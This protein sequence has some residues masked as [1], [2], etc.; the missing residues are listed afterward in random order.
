MDHILFACG[1]GGT[2]AG[3]ALG[4]RLYKHQQEQQQQQQQQQ[5]EEGPGEEGSRHVL[6]VP[7]IH[8]VGVCDSPDVFYDHIRDM[9]TAVGAPLDVLGDVTEWI[10]LYDGMGLGY[11]QSTTDELAYL[12]AVSQATGTST[13]LPSLPP[14]SLPPPLILTRPPPLILTR[15]PPLILTRPPPLI[16]TRP[17]PLILT[18]PG[19]LLDPVYSG[20]AAF[21]AGGGE[22]A[23]AQGLF[24]A[25]S[26]VLFLHT[27]GVFG[28]YDKEKDIL[29]CGNLPQ[30]AVHHPW[31]D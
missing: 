15:P 29:G 31:R 12:T 22:G 21:F 9:A 3:L 18:P 24:S 10:T 19:I 6:K 5:P 27:G 13:S 25:N 17:P 28:V 16:L 14:L 1:S 7:S 20:K 30:D 2:A 8:A 11:A 4:F 26:K 23:V